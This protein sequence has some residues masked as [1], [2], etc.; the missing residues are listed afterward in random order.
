MIVHKKRPNRWHRDGKI[1]PCGAILQERTLFRTEKIQEY[2]Y[3]WKVV[4]CPECLKHR[5]NVYV[6]HVNKFKE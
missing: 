3:L 2:S 6:G 4:T 1:A 5:E